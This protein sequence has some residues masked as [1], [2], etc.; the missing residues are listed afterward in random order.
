MISPS[1]GLFC[2]LLSKLNLLFPELPILTDYLYYICDYTVVMLC[3][4]ACS[5]FILDDFQRSCQL[6]GV[7][8]RLC[9]QQKQ[10]NTTS[11]RG[12]ETAWLSWNN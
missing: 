9:W 12:G 10:K 7:W 6:I 3:V 11:H 4:A 2:T 8:Q 5:P 1:F